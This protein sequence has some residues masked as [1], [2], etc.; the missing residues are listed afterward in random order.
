MGM[1]IQVWSND[2]YESVEHRVVVNSKKERFS[3]PFFFFPAFDTI[4]KPL[5]ELVNEQSPA[6]YREYSWGKFFVNRNRSDFKRRDVENI[7]ISHFRV[8]D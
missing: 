8:S 4:V 3:I 6:K 5:E 2:K 1:F 7:Q